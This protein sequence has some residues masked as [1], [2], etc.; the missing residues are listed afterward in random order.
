MS[1]SICNKNRKRQMAEF[2]DK[3]REVMYRY[4]EITEDK[5]SDEQLI[6]EM[7]KLIECDKD[8]YDPY[9]VI[10]DVLLWQGK[11]SEAQIFCKEAYQRAV[12][13]IADSKGRWPKFM[14]WGFLENRHLMRA[15]EY[16][17][18]VRWEEKNIDEAL[19]IY[20][21]LLRLNPNDNQGARYNILAIRMGLGYEEWDKPFEVKENGEAIGLDA[22]KVSKWFHKNA[23]KF[24][25]EF[26]W[27]FQYHA[28]NE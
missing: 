3:N 12:D 17:A 21:R 24:P 23:K 1:T 20:R 7:K 27:F 25:D 19:D 16:Y 5:L 22:F 15:L 26:E 11:K 4:Y 14:P 28:K 8:F 9:L 13:W 2:I 10:S 18:D 6:A